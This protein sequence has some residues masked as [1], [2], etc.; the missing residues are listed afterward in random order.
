[1]G[2]GI[3]PI[4][5]AYAWFVRAANA[6][7]SLFLLAV[8][9]YWGWQFTQTGWGIECELPDLRQRRAASIHTIGQAEPQHLPQWIV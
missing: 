4:E 8:R 7:Q 9:L 3:E 2:S 5:R 1:M 6:C